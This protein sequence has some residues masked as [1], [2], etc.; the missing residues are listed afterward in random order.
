LI[1]FGWSISTTLSGVSFLKDLVPDLV[2]DL[3]PNPPPNAG[4]TALAIAQSSPTR[5]FS[6][7]KPVSGFICKTSSLLGFLF[8]NS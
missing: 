6:D 2:P 1:A 5:G 7:L 3:I 4:I 8:L